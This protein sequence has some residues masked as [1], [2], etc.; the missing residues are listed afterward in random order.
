MGRLR[1]LTRRSADR[2]PLLYAHR[3]N[4]KSI[5]GDLHK[6]CDGPFAV[7]TYTVA[8]YSI[9]YRTAATAPNPHP[10]P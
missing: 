8:E 7:F 3:A 4:P 5:I 9:R 2:T 6:T 1:V 10:T